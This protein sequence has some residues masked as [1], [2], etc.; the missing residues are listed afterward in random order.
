MMKRT[1][2]VTLLLLATA[3]AHAAFSNAQQTGNDGASGSTA[4]L[5]HGLN[6]TSGDIVIALIH[7][8]N[9][10][11]TIT[12]TSTGGGAWTIAVQD[13]GESGKTMKYSLY[14]KIAN[15]SEPAD[16]SWDVGGNTRWSI[17]L[18]VF[19]TENTPTVDASP[20]FFLESSATN[21]G[22]CASI[23]VAVDSLAVCFAMD[24]NLN[25]PSDTVDNG[26]TFNITQ[27]GGIGQTIAGAYKIATSAGASGITTFSTMG[28]SSESYSVHMSFV[29]GAGGG[30]SAVPIIH[31]QH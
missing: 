29:D 5:T 31:Q 30:G 20:T 26:Y 24:D 28:Q 13:R 6:I 9:N 4:S 19:D 21:G 10:G 18:M 17:G 7:S 22:E 8:N 3:Q 14:W 27:G 16:Y 1:L 11:A 15:G 12:D 23:T 25:E 2:L